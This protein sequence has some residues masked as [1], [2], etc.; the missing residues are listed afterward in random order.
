MLVNI[1][2]FYSDYAGNS[3]SFNAR[4][5]RHMC[6]TCISVCDCDIGPTGFSIASEANDLLAKYSKGDREL[7]IFNSSAYFADREE[8]E[9]Y[10]TTESLSQQQGHGMLVHI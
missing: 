3:F 2:Y 9:P 1:T 6:N 7:D 8:N 4:S 5:L 10:K